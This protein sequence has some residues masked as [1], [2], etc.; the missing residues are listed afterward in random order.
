M[1]PAAGAEPDFAVVGGGLVGAAVAYGLAR[2]GARVAVLD[3][4]DIAHRLGKPRPPRRR[5]DP[6][7]PTLKRPRTHQRGAG[8]QC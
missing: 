8:R 3:E 6:R 7:Q 2:G 4:G 5:A 1:T